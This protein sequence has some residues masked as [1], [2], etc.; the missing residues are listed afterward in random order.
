MWKI[1][2]QY[3]DWIFLFFFS[4]Q[5]CDHLPCTSQSYFSSKMA[6]C[7]HMGLWSSWLVLSVHCFRAWCSA[8]L[9]SDWTSLILGLIIS[10]PRQLTLTLKTLP[11]SDKGHS[12]G[13]SLI[14]SHHSPWHCRSFFSVTIKYLSLSPVPSS[15]WMLGNF[16]PLFFIRG[17]P[18]E[19]QQ[20]LPRRGGYRKS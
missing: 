5:L 3:F 18:T 8:C 4:I 9:S 15:L 13:P 14:F 12:H 7:R 6:A 20:S 2:S 11:T 16:F 1:F 19:L 10:S 17:L